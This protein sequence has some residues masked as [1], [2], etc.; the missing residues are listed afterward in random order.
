MRTLRLII[1]FI[2][3]AFI[4]TGCFLKSVHPLVTDKDAILLEGLEGIWQSDDQRWVFMNDMTKFPEFYEPSGPYNPG[5]PGEEDV[6]SGLE[7][8]YL[9]LF[10]NLQDI[11]ADTSLFIAKVTK[12]DDNHF[13]DLYPVAR[14]LDEL[15]EDDN[16]FYNNHLFPVHSISKVSIKDGELSIEMYEDTWIAE[17]M[18][19]N[20]IRIKHESVGE[21]ILITADTEELRKFVGKYANSAKAFDDPITLDFKGYSIED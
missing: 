13:L 10:E 4:F 17:M 5:E 20:R 3:P 1:G 11:E 6:D 19:S 15:E 7:N 14:T 12:I 9:V 16:T 18:S 21:D 8:A 2:L